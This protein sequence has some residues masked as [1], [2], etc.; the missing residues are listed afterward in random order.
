MLAT[1]PHQTIPSVEVRELTEHSIED[2]I[3]IGGLMHQL[4]PAFSNEPMS[5]ETFEEI[6][7]SPHHGLLG[8]YIGDALVGTATMTKVLEPAISYG[9]MGGFVIDETRRGQ[10]I[11]Q[12][13]WGE[14][15]AWCRR[16]NLDFFLFHTEPEREAAIKFY[17]KMGATLLDPQENYI[18]R[19]DV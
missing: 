6:S 18:Y 12:A 1:N 5:R 9:F 7:T 14:M 16:H 10:G 3:V 15:G 8:A 19:V 17:Q 2:A 4:D 13:L 11:A